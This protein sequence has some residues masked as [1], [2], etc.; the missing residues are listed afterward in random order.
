MSGSKAQ[1]ELTIPEGW[2]LEADGYGRDASILSTP[3]PNVYFA[4][5]DWRERCFRS[6]MTTMGQRL[7]P[8]EY[9]G[10]GWRQRLIDDAAKWLSK[11]L[12]KP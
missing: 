1:D 12:R 4:T 7:N 5:I 3:S 2:K 9:K 10:A 8:R 6:G 11:L